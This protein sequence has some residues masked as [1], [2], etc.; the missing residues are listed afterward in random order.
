MCAL[1]KTCNFQDDVNNS[2]S[3]ELEDSFLLI[4][5]DWNKVD[6]AYKIARI[7]KKSLPKLSEKYYTH[8]SEIRKNTETIR[9]KEIKD[10]LY[11]CIDLLICTNHYLLKNNEIDENRIEE[12][13]IK[14]SLISGCIDKTRL[15]SKLISSLQTNGFIR[16]ANSIINKELLPL[17]D[18][19]KSINS[20]SKEFE[21][22]IVHAAPILYSYDKSCFYRYFNCIEDRIIKSETCNMII[23]HILQKGLLDEPYFYNDKTTHDIEFNDVMNIFSLMEE[24]NFD[25]L[26]YSHLKRLSLTLK[27][28]MKSKFSDAQ[29]A[30]TLRQHKII[31]NRFPLGCGV[32]HDGY[33]IC[34]EGLFL[35]ITGERKLTEWTKLFDKANKIPNIA[36]TVF[37]KASLLE[38]ATTI[39]LT[40]RKIFLK[41]I[42]NDVNLV[43]VSVERID[44]IEHIYATCKGVCRKTVKKA[45]NDALLLSTDLDNFEQTDKRKD[46]VDACYDLDDKFSS[47]ISALTSSDERKRKLIED[48]I[49]EKKQQEKAKESFLENNPVKLTK[50]TQQEYTRLC[51]EQIAKIN[52]GKAE[53][54]KL[55]QFKSYLSAVGDFNQLNSNNVLKCFIFTLGD[56]FRNTPKAKDELNT[57]F[58]ILSVNFKTFCDIYHLKYFYTKPLQKNSKSLVVGTGEAERLKSIRYISDIIERSDS[59]SISISEPYFNLE[60]LKF[61]SEVLQHTYSY[62]IKIITSLKS[63][64]ELKIKTE[65]NGGLDDI[66]ELLNEY[67][68]SNICPDSNPHIELIFC[69]TDYDNNSIL[70]DRWWILDDAK[71]CFKIGTSIN[72]IGSKYCSIDIVDEEEFHNHSLNIHQVVNKQ[73]RDFKGNRVKYRS[74]FLD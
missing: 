48:K 20:K 59:N 72:G 11:N 58:E 33:K 15:Y 45:I 64:K 56:S 26:L 5:G 7:L 2:L 46:L 47:T 16:N 3:K 29:K 28:I 61:I 10:S 25:W 9:V 73:V 27:Y 65:E 55:P 52:A 38:M 1:Q 74:A 39:N 60:D 32:N 6:V 51:T 66:E 31:Q 35:M 30:E 53:R 8:A 49:N 18:E 70:H 4:D 63:Y 42:I 71:T 22:T 50:L 36:D 13:L 24:L 40:D 57:I 67:W 54:K 17:I 14:T 44:L 21:L 62:S 19:L 34:S 68:I 43:N 37:T 41:N 69:G 12:I 23:S